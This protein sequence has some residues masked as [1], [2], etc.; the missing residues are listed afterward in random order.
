V[1]TDERMARVGRPAQVRRL[2][3]GQSRLEVVRWLLLGLMP[4]LAVV[5]GLA[6]ALARRGR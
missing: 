6:V 3:L 4:A 2:E 1:R 5:G